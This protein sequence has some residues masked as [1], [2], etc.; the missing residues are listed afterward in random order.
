MHNLTNIHTMVIKSRMMTL[1]CMSQMRLVG[2]PQEKT[3]F[4]KL[5]YRLEITSKYILQ[6]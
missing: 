6:K 1:E 4:M 3:M 2:E 5:K